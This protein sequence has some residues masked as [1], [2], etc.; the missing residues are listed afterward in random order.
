MQVGGLL[1]K[2]VAWVLLACIVAQ[3][4][5]A[6]L[7]TFSDAA[8]WELHRSFVKGFALAPLLLFLLSY[9]SGIKGMKRWVSLGLFA[10]VVFQFVSIQ[11]FSSAGVIAALHPVAAMLLF[12][13]SVITV[14]SNPKK[15]QAA[16]R[17]EH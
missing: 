9:A 6:G 13:G 15:I 16:S 8:N 7:A 3:A 11:V 10:L 17:K 12:W 2:I 4:F 14:K 1:F 5:I